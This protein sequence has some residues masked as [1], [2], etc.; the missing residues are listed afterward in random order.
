MKLVRILGNSLMI[1]CMCDFFTP[2]KSQEKQQDKVEAA[3]QVLVDFSKMKESIPSELLE[4]TQGIII[5]PK[6]INA[7][8]VLSGKRGKGLAMVK[9]EEGTGSNQ[10]IVKQTGGGVGWEGGRQ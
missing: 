8:F 4:V 1:I 10:E 2:V 7:G 3:T 5:V 9:L 6:L